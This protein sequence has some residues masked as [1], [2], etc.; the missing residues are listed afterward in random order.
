M[1]WSKRGSLS[2][3]KPEFRL[4]I[5]ASNSTKPDLRT[6]DLFASRAVCRRK[7]SAQSY[8]RKINDAEY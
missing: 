1:S 5:R 2:N 3:G 7:P 6:Q 4:P 8:L